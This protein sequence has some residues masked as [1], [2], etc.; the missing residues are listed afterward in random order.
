MEIIAY[1]LSKAFDGKFIFKN[2]NFELEQGD[3]LF[4]TGK[5]GSGKT[6]L[7]KVIS[8]IIRPDSGDIK[9]DGKSIFSVNKIN[10]LIFIGHQNA[11]YRN[12]TVWE[13]LYLWGKICAKNLKREEVL[14]ALEVFGIQRYI[15][16]IIFNLSQGT[17]KKVALSKVFI[18]NPSIL[19]VDEPFSNLDDQGAETFK[20]YIYE[21]VRNGGIFIFSSPTVLDISFSKQIY[22]ESLENI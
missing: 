22:L 12:L 18:T 14:K 2:I 21:F 9:I 10:E 16:H 15:D 4:V 5:N 3:T 19:I 7:L 6:T 8:G 20:K 17:R 11:L 1:N 13:N